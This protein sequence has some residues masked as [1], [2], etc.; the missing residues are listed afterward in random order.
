[1]SSTGNANNSN[2]IPCDKEFL[3]SRDVCNEEL[4]IHSH[5]HEYKHL[6]NKNSWKDYFQTYSPVESDTE[7][8]SK[9]HRSFSDRD[10]NIQDLDINDFG[11][12]DE[13]LNEETSNQGCSRYY[14]NII[15]S[16]TSIKLKQVIFPN[17]PF[18]SSFSLSDGEYDSEGSI[19]SSLSAKI[20]ESTTTRRLTIE[21]LSKLY[22]PE[23]TMDD[24]LQSSIS[25]KRIKTRL[26]NL[27]DN[28]NF[29]FYENPLNAITFKGIKY[30]K[31]DDI[32]VDEYNNFLLTESR[33]EIHRIGI[34]RQFSSIEHVDQDYLQPFLDGKVNIKE[35]IVGGSGYSRWFIF[36]NLG[37]DCWV[38]S[39]SIDSY[40][41]L[42]GLKSAPEYKKKARIEFRETS[43]KS[44]ISLLWG[45]PYTKERI[46]IDRKAIEDLIRMN[47][48]D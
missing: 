26:E 19:D 39:M 23:T 9:I 21:S 42:C 32:T 44:I 12:G 1:M 30:K 35:I 34:M 31:G 7:Y 36:R 14:N 3:S 43:I 48:L 38:V 11:D 10:L 45:V 4:D 2:N 40:V 27:E 6:M 24:F 13:M 37:G 47:E 18:D 33:G 22:P 20:K 41:L 29:E 17:M 5:Y 28:L 15:G 46:I 25:Q 8:D 16:T